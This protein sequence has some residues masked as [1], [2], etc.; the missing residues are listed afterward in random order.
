[1]TDL[2]ESIHGETRWK[3]KNE[4]TKIKVDRLYREWSAI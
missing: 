1:M 3:K 2:K 4:K